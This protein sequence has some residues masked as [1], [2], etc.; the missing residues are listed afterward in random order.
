MGVEE[1]IRPSTTYRPEGRLAQH[2]LDELRSF[3]DARSL[4]EVQ[5]S[6]GARVPGKQSRPDFPQYLQGYRTRLKAVDGNSI[7]FEFECYDIGHLYNLAHML[8][9]ELVTPL[10]VQTVFGILGGIGP[11]P[12]DV[13]HMRRT[14]DRLFGDA[15]Q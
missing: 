11:H 14:A 6:V 5:A 9:R 1:R 7:K 12:E 13:L 2:E 3:P 15:Y 10:F 4:Q 8:D